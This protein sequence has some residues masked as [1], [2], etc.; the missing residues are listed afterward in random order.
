MCSKRDLHRV[1]QQHGA[2]VMGPISLV[3]W[4]ID[5]IGP[6]PIS[7]EYQY[8]ISCVDMTTRLLVAFPE[9]C[10]YQHTTKRGLEL[11]VAANSRMEVI[12][13]DQGTHFSGYALQEWVQQ[14]GI[15][16]KFHVPYN[17]TRAGMIERYNSSLKSGLKSDT[18]TLQGWSVRLW[19]ALRHLNER[20]RKG[21]LS[22]MEMLTHIAVSPI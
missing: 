9:H 12:E 7:E 4:Q 20:P 18:N 19:T 6:L 16:W 13:R 17:P 2:I 10:A 11:L 5:Y 22:P 3:R 8:A 14:L 21:A 1:P 15:K